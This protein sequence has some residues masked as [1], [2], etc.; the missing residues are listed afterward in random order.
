[1]HISQLIKE[2]DINQIF[3]AFFSG[4]YDAELNRA[5]MTECS[6]LRRY[7]Y[8]KALKEVNIDRYMSFARYAATASGFKPK[9]I[10]HS[11]LSLYGASEDDLQY[12]H[13]PEDGLPKLQDYIEIAKETK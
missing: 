5:L 6:V 3:R 13:K 4:Q 10:F 8:L 9:E 2:N 11:I 7:Y 12:C 1:M